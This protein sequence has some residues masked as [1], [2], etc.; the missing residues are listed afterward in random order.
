M[1]S[2]DLAVI[3]PCAGEGR[4]LGL[5]LPK[6]LFEVIPGL[7]LIDLTLSHLQLAAEK[8]INFRMVIVVN[9]TTVDVFDYVRDRF[10]EILVEACAFN[11]S[12]REWPG[13][14]FSARPLFGSSNVVLLPD[15]LLFLSDIEPLR[16]E[17]DFC[18][19][20]RMQLGLEKRPVHFMVVRDRS[21]ALSRLGAVLAQQGELK[22]LDD[23]PS[24]DLSLFNGF[25]ASYGFKAS[26]G[27]A[28]YSHLDA[29]VHKQVQTVSLCDLG[30]P[31]ADF[32]F[33]YL[34]LGTWEAIEAFRLRYPVRGSLFKV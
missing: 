20:E 17:E 23:K 8:G 28:L 33:S 11:D 27:A 4:R 9:S 29:V 6:P 2:A 30:P 21:P 18:L 15:S 7:R 14:V 12:Y 34:D 1:A 10:P 5:D 16:D 3:L 19:L 24:K 13:S 26:H 31:G 22:R 25:W 32:A